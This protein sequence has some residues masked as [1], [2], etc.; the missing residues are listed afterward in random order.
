MATQSN[1][2]GHP[3][4]AAA[5]A[6][7]IVLPNNALLQW[8]GY[9]LLDY[10]HTAQGLWGRIE[11][12]RGT[13]DDICTEILRLVSLS[14]NA[15]QWKMEVCD[16]V[17]KFFKM[18]FSSGTEVRTLSTVRIVDEAAILSVLQVRFPG[19]TLFLVS[20]PNL[21]SMNLGNSN[22]PT[23]PGSRDGDNSGVQ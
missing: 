20:P 21:R 22:A 4:A 17:N 11:H 14:G 15:A 5:A 18:T 8:S 16:H 13:Y 6:A 2:P 12:R 10:T 23:A 3:N 7:P 9:T 19:C 1:E